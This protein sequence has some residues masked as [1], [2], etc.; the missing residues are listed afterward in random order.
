VWPTDMGVIE[1]IAVCEGD[2]H[3]ADRKGQ[4]NGSNCAPKSGRA[5]SKR[6]QH[7][8]HQAASLAQW[9]RETVAST[10]VRR[11]SRPSAEP[12]RAVLQKYTSQRFFVR[13]VGGLNLFGV[14]AVD[15]NRGPTN[16]GCKLEREPKSG[17][18]DLSGMP[19]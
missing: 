10:I 16:G 8:E 1:E 17:K 11:A 7:D 13:A 4:P 6:G 3:V 5:S 18:E 15:E 2:H 19:S 14:R 12:F 9:I